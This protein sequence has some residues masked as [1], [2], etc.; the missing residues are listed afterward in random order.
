MFFNQWL[1][2]VFMRINEI[3]NEIYNKAKKACK[4]PIPVKIKGPVTEET[5]IK[6]LE[7]EQQIIHPGD[8]V[9]TGIQ[10]EE[11]PISANVFRDYEPAFE[12]GEKMYKKKAK[13]VYAYKV[14]FSGEVATSQGDIL[15]FK[16]GYYIVMESPENLW[17]VDG[18][19]FEESYDFL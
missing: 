1:K 18:K 8:Y 3:A 13:I 4:K 10:G 17:A 5:L 14:D 15:S 6:T 11:Y 7:S 2:G 16:P 19:V 12:V 9:V